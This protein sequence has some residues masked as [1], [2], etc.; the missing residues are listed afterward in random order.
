MKRTLFTIA[1]LIV[2]VALAF[3]VLFSTHPAGALH[4]T[5]PWAD[6]LAYGM[7]ATP[8]Q[9]QPSAWDVQVHVRDRQSQ[10]M[11]PM[12]ADHGPDCAAP[13]AK[14]PISSWTQAV[15]VCHNHVMTAIN[16]GGYGEVVLTPDHMA[17][18]SS[19]PV[20]VAFSLSTM[21]TNARD[22]FTI[23]LSPFAEHLSL[24]FDFFGVDLEG[25]PLH[26]VSLRADMDTVG[27]NA[28]THWKLLREQT[29][30]GDETDTG[31]LVDD[32]FPFETHTGIPMSASARTPFEF[33]FDST[34]YLFRVAPSAPIGGGKVIFQGTFAHPL[35]F[36]QGVL[37]F[38]HHSYDAEKC[39]VFGVTCGPNTWHISDI[40]ISSA[41]PYTL[42]RPIDHQVVNNATSPVTFSA[43]A[44]AGAYLKFAGMY[45][46]QISLDGG[47]TWQGVQ[48]APID[49]A[50]AN[51]T[52]GHAV[53]VMTPI[54][55][56]TTQVM[57][58]SP[59]ARDFSIVSQGASGPAPS[60]TPIPPTPTST[61][62][63]PSPT[64]TP[65]PIPLNH[66]PCVVTL[67]GV[68]RA[69][70]CDGTFTPS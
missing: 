39:D 36:T 11:D 41:V 25:M 61:P 32:D 44:P 5:A 24:P 2:T 62:V 47:R 55:A 43:P 38:A 29:G 68:Q 8:T 48:R 45:N 58:R 20:T 57:V 51:A 42:L 35:T 16:N 6:A 18:W 7:P 63:P 46:T 49:V 70:F 40:G 33:T 27:A 3:S 19:G 4:A 50:Y 23:S 12:N 60:P 22:W 10:G 13:P 1:P 54:P 52:P 28:Y 30:L 21:R 59:F 66:T 26:Y 9:W 17:D 56:G 14:H 15:F 37:Q 53:N 64:P 34:H 31:A 67:N 65:A 69:G